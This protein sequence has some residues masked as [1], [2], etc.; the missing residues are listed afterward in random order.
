MDLN[1]PQSTEKATCTTPLCKWWPKKWD[2]PLC[3]FHSISEKYLLHRHFQENLQC[4]ASSYCSQQ[5][6][7]KFLLQT[8]PP[9]NT[10]SS[11]SW[12]VFC[13]SSFPTPADLQCHSFVSKLKK[14]TLSVSCNSFFYVPSHTFWKVS[15]NWK[16]VCTSLCC[17]LKDWKKEPC[18]LV[19]CFM[20]TY[21]AIHFS[22][23]LS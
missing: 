19:V 17:S 1:P 5:Y 4:C 10:M 23:I 7:A 2:L 6:L 11:L 18:G 9:G 3:Q 8:T 15:F 21:W 22:F 20:G 16:E 12:Q 14:P 13:A